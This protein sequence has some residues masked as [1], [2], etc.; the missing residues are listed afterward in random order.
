MG[1][2]ATSRV[3]YTLFVGQV[4]VAQASGTDER[5][6]G[7]VAFECRESDLCTSIQVVFSQWKNGDVTLVALGRAIDRSG[8]GH[9]CRSF[10]LGMWKL[11]MIGKYD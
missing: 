3:G 6:D 2:H 11:L 8:G 9:D 10:D 5:I 4:G 1:F 7:G